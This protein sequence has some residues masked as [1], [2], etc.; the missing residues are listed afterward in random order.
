MTT[1]TKTKKTED[2][3]K[4]KKNQI[5]LNATIFIHLFQMLI[6]IFPSAHKSYYAKAIKPWG[7]KRKG[8]QSVCG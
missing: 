1:T 7:I 6:L 4:K 3:K 2:K 5:C 8:K